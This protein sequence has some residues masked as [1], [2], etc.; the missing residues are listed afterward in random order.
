MGKE[1]AMSDTPLREAVLPDPARLPSIRGFE[2]VASL[3]KGALGTT[4]SAVHAGS[5]AQVALKLLFPQWC[6]LPSTPARIDHLSRV[7]PGIRHAGIARFGGFEEVPGTRVRYVHSAHVDGP[8]L[9]LLL[10]RERT[11]VRQLIERFL[12]ILDALGEAHQQ[13]LAH[14]GIKPSNVLVSGTGTD[15]RVRLCDFGLGHLLQYDGAAGETLRLQDETHL[16][17]SSPEQ[18]LG[19]EADGRSDI[20]SVGTLMYEAL[21]GAHPFDADGTF[22]TIQAVCER[23]PIPPTR[24]HPDRRVPRELE[25][26]CMRALRKLPEDRFRSPGEMAQ[27]MRASLEILG[28]RAD[29]ALRAPTLPPPLPVPTQVRSTM[30]GEQLRS[31][32]K[33]LVGALL[34]IGTAAAMWWLGSTDVPDEGP[35]PTLAPSP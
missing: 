22:D 23:E 8:Q 32:T 19:V 33:L 17:Y 34:L 1:P 14:L 10:A 3:G 18:L 20:F 7:L 9:L 26:V 4:Y 12:E 21:T 25:A 13:G 11:S 35:A 16:R 15:V 29:I 30:P 31:S 6:V 27:A 2:L 5:G 28:T 24:R